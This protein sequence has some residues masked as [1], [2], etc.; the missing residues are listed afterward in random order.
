MIAFFLSYL[1]VYKYAILFFVVA[2]TSVGVP[3][4]ATALIVAAGAFAAQ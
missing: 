2:V 3:L 4:P 1:L